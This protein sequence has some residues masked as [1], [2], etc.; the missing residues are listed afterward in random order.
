MISL[1]LTLVT[2]FGAVLGALV[3]I[4]DG[5]LVGDAEGFF[6]GA[7]VGLCNGPLVG[8]FVGYTAG[9]LV[10]ADVGPLVGAFD[11]VFVGVF[12]G[13]DVGGSV[14]TNEH[15]FAAPGVPLSPAATHC[16]VELHQLSQSWLTEPSDSILKDIEAPSSLGKA[17]PLPH[18]T[19]SISSPASFSITIESTSSRAKPPYP[20]LLLGSRAYVKLSR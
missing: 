7:L 10:G 5:A 13:A 15:L 3:G 14:G 12:V 4:F 6:V 20:V 2:L 1:I 17:D 18:S 19:R 9:D 16:V 8:F 11:G